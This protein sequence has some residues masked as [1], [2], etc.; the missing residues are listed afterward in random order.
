MPKMPDALG[1]RSVILAVVKA[2]DLG[3]LCLR[4]VTVCHGPKGAST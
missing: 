1:Q 3:I 2:E 4:A